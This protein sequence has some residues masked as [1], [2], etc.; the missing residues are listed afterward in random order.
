MT[1]ELAAT[2]CLRESDR[3]RMLKASSCIGPIKLSHSASSIRLA[4]RRSPLPLGRSSKR[5]V[6]HEFASSLPGMP[7]NSMLSNAR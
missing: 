7:N 2:T 5:S 6:D 4:V 3:D 1:F